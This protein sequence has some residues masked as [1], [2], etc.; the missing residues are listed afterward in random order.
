MCRDAQP[1]FVNMDVHN[2]K[3]SWFAELFSLFASPLLPLWV[4]DSNAARRQSK[5]VGGEDEIKLLVPT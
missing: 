4:V 1:Q 5:M 3:S 2:E